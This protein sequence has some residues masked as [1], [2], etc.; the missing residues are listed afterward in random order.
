MGLVGLEAGYEQDEDTDESAVGSREKSHNDLSATIVS[1]GVAVNR[2]HTIFCLFESACT[3][4]SSAAGYGL[5]A[6]LLL[7]FSRLVEVG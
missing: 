1:V 4:G 6:V 3:A 7:T 2:E 5:P